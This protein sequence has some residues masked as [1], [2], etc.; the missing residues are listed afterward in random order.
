MREL[1]Y[2]LD[3]SNGT[4]REQ[5][6]LSYSRAETVLRTLADARST[7]DPSP[8]PGCEPPFALFLDEEESFFMI[9]PEP[10]GLQVTVRVLDKWNL[11]GLLA[12]DKAFT[13]DFGILALDD[14]LTLLRLFYENNYPALRSLEKC[15]KT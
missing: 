15:M 4:L 9:M 8:D 1:R 6:T 14:S 10:E 12:K 11:F 3:L 5:A 2:V 7:R 13:L